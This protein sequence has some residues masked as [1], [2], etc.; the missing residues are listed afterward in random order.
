VLCNVGLQ[1]ES[2]E[3]VIVKARRYGENLY[4][5]FRSMFDNVAQFVKHQKLD[6]IFV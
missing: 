2:V 3:E 6:E 1:Y 4:F 5:L